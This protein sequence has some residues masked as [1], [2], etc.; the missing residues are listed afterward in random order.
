VRG[1][2]YSQRHRVA[3][4]SA[5]ELCRC[6]RERCPRF[7]R[8]KLATV[9]EQPKTTIGSLNRFSQC[10]TRQAA[11]SEV[12]LGAG[13]LSIPC[14]LKP[15]F[16][17]GFANHDVA[18]TCLASKSRKGT[19]QRVLAASLSHCVLHQQ[20]TAQAPRHSRVRRSWIPVTSSLTT[21]P[22]VCF[23]RPLQVGCRAG[24][25]FVRLTMR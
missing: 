4:S 9:G 18:A 20:C 8:S 6:I 23:G 2:E 7:A 15:F 16:G 19:N 22:R 5:P 11:T 13:E 10:H 3:N 24:R 1:A 17:D 14:T 21:I 25:Y 12:I